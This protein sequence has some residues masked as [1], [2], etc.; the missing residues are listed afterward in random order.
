MTP[1]ERVVLAAADAITDADGTINYLAD[2]EPLEAAVQALRTERNG[3]PETELAELDITYGQ[4]VEGDEILSVRVG[5][6]YEV[7]AVVALAGGKVRITMP[8]TGSVKLG[9]KPH[10]EFDAANPVRV[11]RGVTGQAVDMF[12]TVLWSVATK[13]RDEPVTEPGLD[14]ELD[15]AADPEASEIDPVTEPETDEDEVEQ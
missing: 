9:R 1:G 8:K 2:F 6:W 4:V 14:L 5:K 3:R 15:V 10:H 13:P 12:A 7:T 11:R